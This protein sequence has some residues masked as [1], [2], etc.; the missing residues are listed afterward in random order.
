MT[1]I[2]YKEKIVPDISGLLP[3]IISITTKRASIRVS[4]FSLVP[5]QSFSVSW[6]FT[7]VSP[8]S[9]TKPPSIDVNIKW[10]HYVLYHPTGFLMIPFG[11]TYRAG[12]SPHS[13]RIEDLEG[14]YSDLSDEF[15]HAPDDKEIVLE[16]TWTGQDWDGNL[17]GTVNASDWLTVNCD[18]PVANWWDWTT[19]TWRPGVNLDKSYA[20]RGKVTNRHKFAAAQKVTANLFKWEEGHEKPQTP[21]KSKTPHSL[22]L[23]PGASAPIDFGDFSDDWDWMPDCWPP[24]WIL[25]K[26]FTY[27]VI[28][29]V[30][31]EF[32]NSYND[33]VPQTSG[34]IVGVPSELQTD[35]KA[36]YCGFKVGSALADLIGSIFSLVGGALLGGSYYLEAWL[37]K[38]S[39]KAPEADADFKS[40][41]T[42]PEIPFDPEDAAFGEGLPATRKFLKAGLEISVLDSMRRSIVRKMLGARRA[43]QPKDE[44]SQ[45]DSYS[46]VL[47]EIKQKFQTLQKLGDEA[48]AEL[49]ELLSQGDV[50]LPD[51]IRLEELK[52]IEKLPPEAL[53]QFMDVLASPDL[54]EQ[55]RQSQSF[56][57]TAE[58]L[59]PVIAAI[60]EEDAKT[61]AGGSP[62]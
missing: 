37:S 58:A 12:E 32:G 23:L 4:P 42:R 56:R 55:V 44:K 48:D 36:F 50:Q 46:K 9:F 2:S 19:P 53:D 52:G 30:E 7:W 13:I 5:G 60:E 15:Y 10:Q 33:T 47:G 34:V 8:K 31:D 57:S 62:G 43:G 29:A 49:A 1:T 20:L 59:L 28:L 54:E 25:S 51:E 14:N 22:P 3:N 21:V 61:L 6:G 45:R 39:L 35:A 18:D 24:D 16:I 41:V 26:Q 38:G 11:G 40:K 27:Q 17:S